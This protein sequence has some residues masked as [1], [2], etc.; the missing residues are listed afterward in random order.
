MCL[1]YGRRSTFS[2]YYIFVLLALKLLSN[3]VVLSFSKS[4]TVSL[5]Q[6]HIF[7]PLS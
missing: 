7:F 5:A 6:E 2:A 3:T 4:Q 1:A